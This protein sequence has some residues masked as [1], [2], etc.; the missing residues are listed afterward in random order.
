[1]FKH[2]LKYEDLDGNEVEGTFYFHISKGDI[3]DMQFEGEMG[4][5]AELQK[6]IDTQDPIGIRDGFKMFLERSV[7]KRSDDNLQF[8]KSPEITSAFMNSDAYGTMLIQLVSDTE[9]AV[10]FITG[11]FPRNASEDIQKK[12][13]SG[14]IQLP[15][16]LA[17]AAA[18]QVDVVE[19]PSQEPA[20]QG[21]VVEAQRMVVEQGPR[22][23]SMDELLNMST[24]EFQEVAGNDPTKMSRVQ[25]VAA[26]QRRS[27]GKDAS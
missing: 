6:V 8:I 17:A 2:T 26:M 12:I 20:V 13:A 9:L 21:E 24:E 25:L 10:R 19:L 27:S 16:P 3:A 5:L 15:G 14:E 23:Y 4:Y 22:K 1:M 18:K 7:G 11:I